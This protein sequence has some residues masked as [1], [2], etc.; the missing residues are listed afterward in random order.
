M[1]ALKINTG[2]KTIEEIEISSW[3]DIAPA[4]GNGCELFAIPIIFE[5]EDGIYVDDEGLFNDFQGGF[6]L[7]DW[8]YPI[9]G[10]ALLV[11]S[12]DDGNSVDVKT[13]VD[14]LEKMVIWVDMETC[15]VWAD[16][17]R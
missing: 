15:N 14:D 10:N 16:N 11:G 4:I 6:M 17:F 2:N 13:S 1:K 3:K 5:N 12:D 8:E 7:K 9:V